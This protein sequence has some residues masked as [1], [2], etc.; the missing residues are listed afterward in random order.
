MNYANSLIGRQFKTVVQTLVFHVHDLVSPLQYDLIKAVGEL[1]A[2]LWVVSIGDIEQYGV[3]DQTLLLELNF[4]LSLQEDLDVCVANVLDL[5]ALNDPSKI[6]AKI[7]LH[8]LAHAREHVTRFG[9]LVGSSTEIMECFNSI[10]RACSI[11]SN[12]QAPSRDIAIQLAG[13]ECAKQRLTGGWWQHGNGTWVR[14]S[15]QV[16]AYL[17]SHSIIKN[18]LGWADHQPITPGMN[19]L[20]CFPHIHPS[21]MKLEVPSRLCLLSSVAKSNGPRRLLF[22]LQTN[23]YMIPLHSGLSV[24]VSRLVLAMSAQT[25]LGFLPTTAW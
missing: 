25:D 24:L 18:H 2:L 10:F 14:A 1:T 6:T 11:L 7:K 23:R 12:H 16:R 15:G 9:P 20:P 21:D 13:L 5:F 22:K 8:L 4:S 3:R 19:T 17:S